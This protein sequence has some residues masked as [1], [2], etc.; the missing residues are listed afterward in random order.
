MAYLFARITRPTLFWERLRPTGTV[1][2]FV[3]GDPEEEME[4]QQLLEDERAELIDPP[5]KPKRKVKAPKYGTT[6]PAAAEIQK[7]E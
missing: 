1:L 2:R 5:E 3:A 6:I 4:L 7:W